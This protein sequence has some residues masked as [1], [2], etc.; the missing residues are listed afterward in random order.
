MSKTLAC[1]LLIL[2]FNLG[3]MA[4]DDSWLLGKWELSYDPDDAPKDWLEFTA[5]G[6]VYS[7]GPMGRVEGIYVITTEGVK[8]VF[9]VKENDIIMNFRY[10]QQDRALKIITSRTG[11]AS[12]YRKVVTQ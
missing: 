6:D 9:T 12:V 11:R 4:A 8:A 3:A 10:D 5:A 7:E 1:T 2:F